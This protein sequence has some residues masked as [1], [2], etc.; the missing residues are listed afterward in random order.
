ME[1][2]SMDEQA[3][4]SLRNGTRYQYIM[5]EQESVSWRERYQSHCGTGTGTGISF[6]VE[7]ASI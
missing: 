7:Q 4:I 3:S 5:A 6:M 2:E 1:H